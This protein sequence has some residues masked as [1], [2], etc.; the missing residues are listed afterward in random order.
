MGEHKLTA[1]SKFNWGVAY[2]LVKADTPD[3]TQN[4]LRKEA[5]GYVL[6][7]TSAPDNNRYYQYLVENE[8]VGN[9]CLLYTSRCV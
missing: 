9:G 7:S 4:T 2:N 6:S 5:N 3:R 8:L 1:A